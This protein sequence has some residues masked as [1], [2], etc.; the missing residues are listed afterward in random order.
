LP[1]GKP[2]IFENQSCAPEAKLSLE[3]STSTAIYEELS[4]CQDQ[5]RNGEKFT[6]V[7]ENESRGKYCVKSL[8]LNEFERIDF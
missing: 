2:L 4:E 8:T 5:R 3:I 7:C 6:W 1:L